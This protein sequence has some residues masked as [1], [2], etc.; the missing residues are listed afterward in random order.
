MV[1]NRQSG[2][3][4]TERLQADTQRIQADTAVTNRQWLQADR[5][6]A[7]R[8]SGYKQ[9][10]CVYKQTEWLQADRVVTSRQSGY[11]QWLQADE[12]LQAYR[13]VT[14]SGYKQS[15]YKQTVV[16][17]RQWLQADSAEQ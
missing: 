1:T 8:Q 16:T 17:S 13:V 9:T 11:K 3:K 15:G 4:Q 14:S 10:H 7:S 12:W 5:V 6:V 2:Y